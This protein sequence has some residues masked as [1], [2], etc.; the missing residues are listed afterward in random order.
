LRNFHALE[1][2]E[3]RRRLHD[4]ILAAHTAPSVALRVT[5]ALVPR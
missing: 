3:Q 1:D 5:D 4:I 2:H